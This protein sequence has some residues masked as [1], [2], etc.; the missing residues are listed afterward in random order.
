MLSYGRSAFESVRH[1]T[2]VSGS[3]PEVL[4]SGSL[5]GGSWD[6]EG[7]W[8][9]VFGW[10]RPVLRELFQIEVFLSLAKIPSKLI[11]KLKSNISVNKNFYYRLFLDGERASRTLCC[12]VFL[13]YLSPQT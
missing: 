11:L 2:R 5:T 6:R 7:T 13:Q 9:A 10:E 8:K 1:G 12:D 4:Y 3:P